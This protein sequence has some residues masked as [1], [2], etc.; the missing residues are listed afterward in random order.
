MKWHFNVKHLHIY[1]R[2]LKI[3]TT[4]IKKDLRNPKC[5]FKHFYKI[6]LHIYLF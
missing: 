4:R 2:N 3:N 6:F 1:S 5:I